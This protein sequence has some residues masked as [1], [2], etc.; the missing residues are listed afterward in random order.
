MLDLGVHAYLHKD[1]S[2]AQVGEAIREV[3][4][5]N[6][7]FTEIMSTAMLQR[8]ASGGTSAKASFT[9]REQEVAKLICKELT[10][11]E[12]ATQLALSPRTVETHRRNMVLKSGA[13]NTAGLVVYLV[14]Q[15][16]V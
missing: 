6:Y 13:R 4:K 12:I 11:A 3:V 14:K 5:H 1:S 2:P 15:G 7:Y 9:A 10:T 16:Y 8:I